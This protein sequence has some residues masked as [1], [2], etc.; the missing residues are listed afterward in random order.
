MDEFTVKIASPLYLLRSKESCWKCGS[1]QPVIALA[2]NKLVES[3]AIGPVY[4]NEVF[5]LSDIAEIPSDI[6]EYVQAV[7][8][9]F[10]KRQSK[11]A[12]FSYFANTCKCGALFGDFYLHSEPDGAFFPTTQE[13]AGSISIEKLPF[14]GSYEFSCAYGVGTGS[15][16][17]THGRYATGDALS[18]GSE[19]GEIKPLA[20]DI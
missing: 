5:I 11:T 10:E 16:I 14:E 9:Q 3:G 8:P 6:L 7:N 18:E 20:R 4:E 12:E 19:D 13:Q 15:F 17:F 1:E 2:C